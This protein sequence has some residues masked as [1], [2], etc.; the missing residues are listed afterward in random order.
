MKRIWIFLTVLTFL[1]NV[2][3]PALASD[4]ALYMDEQKML[5]DIT[6]ELLGNTTFVPVRMVSEQLGAKVDYYND[7]SI[8]ISN[9]DDKGS[10]LVLT[11]GSK[12]VTLSAPYHLE[13]NVNDPEMQKFLALPENKDL[14]EDIKRLGSTVFGGDF[15]RDTKYTLSFAPYIK[16]GSTMVPLRFVSEQLGCDVKYEK[17][18]IDIYS[19]AQVLLD[20][21]KISRLQISDNTNKTTIEQKSVLSLC[22]ALIEQSRG[23][24]IAQPQ[25]VSPLSYQGYLYSFLDSAGK[26]TAAWQFYVPQTE[27][28]KTSGWSTMY[29]YDSL[30]Q[31]WYSANGKIYEEYLYGQYNLE[32]YL[33]AR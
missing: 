4:I 10:I 33:N 25:A 15:I 18:R 14:A 13:G 12:D 16:N 1:L 31:K 30:N 32:P 17:G 7:G 23:E 5:S 2:A 20:G 24:T 19:A 28:D 29:L 22:V 26:V 3:T 8:W 11:V 27:A 9:F 21:Q 6:P